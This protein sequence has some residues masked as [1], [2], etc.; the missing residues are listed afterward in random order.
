MLTI[1]NNLLIVVSL[2]SIFFYSHD[3][4]AGCDPCIQAAAEAANA[5][6]TAAINTTTTSVQANVAATNAL[7]SALQA[8]STVLTTTINLN[9]Q[10]YLSA[11]SASTNRI[12]LSI[13]QNTK[14]QERM[15]DHTINSI[16]TALREVRVAEEVDDNN[17]TYSDK[18][19]QPLSGI[20][21]ANRAP[22]LKQGFV[23]S[24]Q[25][26]RQMSDDMHEWNNNTDDV[27]GAGKGMKTAILLTEN[28]DVW[29]PIPL[30]NSRQITNDESLN[31]QKLLT[32][33]VN[34]VPLPSAT[35]A[36]M[37]SNPR[38]PEYEFKRRMLNAKLEIAHA[39]LSKSISD[40]APL[41]PISPDDWQIGYTMAEPEDGKVSIAS[42]LE[43][44]TIGRLSS[45]GWYLDVKS[46][47]PTGQLREQVYQQA[48]N[49]QLTLRLVEQEEQQLMLLSLL[50]ISE[51]EK[52]R[53]TP[54][55]SR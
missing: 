35:P 21:G 20:I 12:E 31:L 24:K 22:L 46:K 52:T 43:S 6:M 42:M 55:V 3:V 44:E 13:Q 33:L 7:N 8:T 40:K 36:Q 47:T 25:M 38:A 51:I 26:W 11:L 45:D 50:T 19:A 28:A 41:I 2:S 4:R 54:P 14:T 49:N 30:I 9:T 17:K 53:P 27:E 10:Q 18:L 34:P 32:M 48:I 23:Q 15:S 37:A 16:V 5:Q 1:R 29:D 39:V